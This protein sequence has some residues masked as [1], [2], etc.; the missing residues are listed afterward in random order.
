[1]INNKKYDSYV[2]IIM[3]LI[4]IFF[5]SITEKNSIYGCGSGCNAY[6]ICGCVSWTDFDHNCC[7]E[8]DEISNC[9]GLVSNHY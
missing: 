6:E 5:F 3:L 9:A 1:M 4:L 2:L 7:G 8:F